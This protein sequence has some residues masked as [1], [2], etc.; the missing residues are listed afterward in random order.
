MWEALKEICRRE[1]CTVHALCSLVEARRTACSLTSA[2]R[3]FVLEYFRAAV[4]EEGHAL[5]GHG[6]ADLPGYAAAGWA[7][8]AAPG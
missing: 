4:T 6:R 7:R 5:A 8:R 1:G 2:I 3:V